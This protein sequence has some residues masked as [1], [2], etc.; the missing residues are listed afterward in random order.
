MRSLFSYPSGWSFTIPLLLLLCDLMSVS[1]NGL[2]QSQLIIVRPSQ[3]DYG[4]AVDVNVGGQDR[5]LM[6]STYSNNLCDLFSL[7]LQTR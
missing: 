4:L 5:R 1:A 3:N 7:N 2:L 6:L